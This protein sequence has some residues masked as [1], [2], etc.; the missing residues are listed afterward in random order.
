MMGFAESV[1][2]ETAPACRP[3]LSANSTR[4]CVVYSRWMTCVGAHAC[5]AA[6]LDQKIVPH[7]VAQLPWYHPIALMGD[8]G[9]LR[10]ENIE[11][12]AGRAV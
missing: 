3:R 6:L 9:E 8:A 7:T 5:A 11:R 1:V 12:F 10:L 2:E 4:K